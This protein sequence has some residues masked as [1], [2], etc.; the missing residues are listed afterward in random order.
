MGL[1]AVGG[2]WPGIY[3]AVLAQLGPVFSKSN[4]EEGLNEG[5]G[6]GV[7]K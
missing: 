6:G 2:L 7:P 3:M 1:P 4:S 5:D